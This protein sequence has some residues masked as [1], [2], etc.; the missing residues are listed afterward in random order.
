MK[1]RPKREEQDPKRLGVLVER[2]LQRVLFGPVNLFRMM[3]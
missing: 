1:W 3:R 2:A